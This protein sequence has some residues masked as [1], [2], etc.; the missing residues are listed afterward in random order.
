[1]K[2]KDKHA[3]ERKQARRALRPDPP[4]VCLGFG[5]DR[6]SSTSSSLNVSN[7][8]TSGAPN[9]GSETPAFEIVLTPLSPLRPPAQGTAARRRR[10]VVVISDI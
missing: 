10:L 7:G 1:M 8:Q 4:V 6:S 5:F 3:R 9:H 2:E